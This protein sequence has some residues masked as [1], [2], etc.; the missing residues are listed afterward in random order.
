MLV[1]C[2]IIFVWPV[3]SLVHPYDLKKM[4]DD[5]KLNPWYTK[6]HYIDD[7]EIGSWNLTRD[8]IIAE[9]TVGQEPDFKSHFD[10]RSYYSFYCEH[11]KKLPENEAFVLDWE[12]AHNKPFVCSL[13]AAD[14]YH[15]DY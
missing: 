7:K 14:E 6:N 12:T 10:E 3:T 2:V 4:G 5:G 13:I 1:I 11:Y 15:P 9:T 8:N